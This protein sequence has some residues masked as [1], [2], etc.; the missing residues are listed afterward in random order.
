MDIFYPCNILEDFKVKKTH[1]NMELQKS[2][3]KKGN[4]VQFYKNFKP[5]V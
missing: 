4:Q 5:I 1:E 3:I 2:K